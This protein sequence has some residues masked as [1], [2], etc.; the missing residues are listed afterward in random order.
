MRR[1]LAAGVLCLGV[2]VGCQ[3]PQR[4][5][6]SVSG[7]SFSISEAR[8]GGGN[9][10]FF[11]ASPLAT[12]PQPG[13]TNFDVGGSNGALRPY[14]R[15]C[16][17]DGT[18]SMAGCLT[19][20]TQ[21]VTGSATGLVMTYGSSAE[22]YQV[23]WSTKALD[24][25]KNY[26]VEVWGR[27]LSGPAQR[28]AVDPRWLFGWRDIANSPSVAACKGTEEFCNV[29]Y[30]Q[31]I[32]IKVRIE[33]YVF[34]PVSR[35]CAVQFVAAGTDANLQV[36]LDPTSG[37]PN[38]QIFIPGQPGTDF[39]F[40]FEPCTAEED[41]ALS[42]AIDL[43]TFGP[44]LKSVTDFTGSLNQPAIVSL[45]S[46]LDPSGFGLAPEQLEQ[47]AMH[48]FTDDLSRAQALPEAWQC[49]TPTSGVIASAGA[50]SRF[51]HLASVVGERLTS[52]VTPRPLMARAPMIDR[53]GGGATSTIESRFKL[54]LPA[55][56]VRG[57]PSY[58]VRLAGSD[59]TLTAK[60][61]DLF[62]NGV[63]SAR[64]HWSFLPPP[65]SVGGDGCVLGGGAGS[66]CAAGD[67]VAYTNASGE[68]QATVRLSTVS[69]NNLY[70]AHGRGIADDRDSGCTVLVPTPGTDASCNGPRASAPY[71]PFDPFM[72]FHDGD[73]FDGSPATGPEY[74]VEITNGTRLPFTVF[75]C[76]P[77][78][79]TATVDGNF[80]DAEWAC[81]KTYNFTA[82]V[83]GGA[84]PA[85]LY[86]MNDA[87]N[88]YFAVR[89]ARSGS[90][91]VNTLQFNFDNNDSW[92]ANG[93]AGAAEAGDEVLSLDAAK[94]FIDAYL[95]LKC[96][97]SS[98]SSCWGTD[99]SDGGTRD[100]SGAFTNDGSYTTYEISHPLNTADN[101]HDFSLSAG[102]KVGLFLTLQTGSGATGNTQWPQFRQYLE[103]S[104]KP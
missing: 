54:A 100:G 28:S 6:P 75:G 78:F 80:T 91:K 27:A 81:A 34:C 12:T 15:I 83:S 92:T 86:V 11:F 33:Q 95:T 102:G 32:P 42:N 16:E 68:A 65:Q 94:G 37:A 85:T 3:D 40:A 67:V 51:L 57:S 99:P 55:K 66:A 7:P 56:F 82:N 101:T 98:Q 93:G 73:A 87:T 22:L 10:D 8:F 18:A 43:P 21:A 17:T 14:V 4:A 50:S 29:N 90:D 77:G 59:V 88:V 9:P 52:W 103:L 1:A 89:L 46:Q 84:T 96:T 48:H 35:D 20:V 63:Q 104:I 41:A 47:L 31:N 53:G 45:C 58:Q 62:G 74:A 25:A 72:P 44:C 36:K 76:Q 64:V 49:G 23:N 19:D 38:A 24:V 79:G 30:G 70:T 69:G 2:L 60:V 61:V 97:S 26:R 39:A 5:N 13:D 71:G